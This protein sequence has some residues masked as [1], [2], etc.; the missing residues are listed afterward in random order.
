MT[1]W[2]VTGAVLSKLSLAA[3]PFMPADACM[4]DN[5]VCRLIA[6]TVVSEVDVTDMIPT[7]VMTVHFCQSSCSLL[8]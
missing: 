8:R 3:L 2:N 6:C 1:Q 5:S 7:V 4:I